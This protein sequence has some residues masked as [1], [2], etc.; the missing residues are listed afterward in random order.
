[1]RKFEVLFFLLL[2]LNIAIAND[3]NISIVPAKPAAQEP[4]NIIFRI[5]S[6]GGVR[7]EVFFNPV[8]IEILGKNSTG[9][10]RRTKFING[11][12]Y[13]E[14][15]VTY[16]YEVVAND[17]TL[18]FIRDIKIKLGDKTIT[19]P[20]KR[21][22]VYRAPQRPKDFM[23][24]AD[25]DKEQLYVGEGITVKYYLLRK[26]NVRN[27]EISKYPKLNKW[28]KRF[29]NK[30]EASRNVEYQGEVFR[31]ELLYSARVFGEKP[32]KYEVDSIGLRVQYGEKVRNDPFGNFG[33]GFQRMKT[34]NIKSP[35]IEIEV[36]PLPEVP[37]TMN[38]TG[39][40]GEHSFR[41]SQPKSRFLVNEAIE[42]KFEVTGGGALEAYEGPKIYVHPRL[43]EFETNSDLR[44]V[45]GDTATKV[46]EYTFLPRAGFQIPK[47]SIKL[48]Y[49]DP[50][51]R[52][53]FEKEI[54]IPGLEIL[55]GGNTFSG[56]ANQGAAPSPKRGSFSQPDL[57]NLGSEIVGLSRNPGFL[58]LNNIFSLVNNTLIGLIIIV[59]L[60]F[61]LRFRAEPNNAFERAKAITNILKK[62][63]GSYKSIFQ[64][65]VLAGGDVDTSLENQVKRLSFS[66]KTESY[67]L[68]LVRSA[69]K[70]SYLE[71]KKTFK[72]NYDNS[73]FNELLKL[74]QSK[75]NDEVESS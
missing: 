33:F 12:V 32:G 8:N 28:L 24:I 63:E 6:M 25:V 19:A 51:K 68:E 58:E 47:K 41:L 49:F 9:M 14:D 43:E 42:M 18:A 16:T 36:L 34:R 55:G 3:V 27:F 52:Q 26:A 21:F 54:N 10:T 4:F 30:P 50:D 45:D 23:V 71:H 37:P 31:R 29:Y 13:T 56:T 57:S 53:Y 35:E 20:D 44:V 67:F 11:K 17:A 62:G 39:L 73:A 7:P 38:F 1:M 61:F 70:K 22:R 40:V 15:E 75:G 60:S 48:A 59:V 5:S 72:I 65:L 46:Y 66:K 64:L 69:Q 74:I 2:G